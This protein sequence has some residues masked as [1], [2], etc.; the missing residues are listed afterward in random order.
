[1]RLDIIMIVIKTEIGNQI[2]INGVM[3]AVMMGVIK[4]WEVKV[5][6]KK[7]GRNEMF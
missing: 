2:N 4:S 1:M 6:V 5:P 3:L 7:E